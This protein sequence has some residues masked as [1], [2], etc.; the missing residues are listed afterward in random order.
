MVVFALCVPTN[1]ALNWLLI[2]GHLGLPPLG[3]AGSGYASAVN[4]WLMLL[5]LAAVFRLGHGNDPACRC[6][7]RGR[8]SAPISA[9]SWRWGCRLPGCRRWRSASSVFSMVLMGLFGADALAAHQ[10]A[11][12]CASITFMV[13]LGLGQAAT[14][15]V[16]AE[17][18]A[19]KRR[20]RRGGRRWPRYPWRCC[21]WPPRPRCWRHFRE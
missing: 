1:A 10:I 13:P 12:N 15:R 14:V 16:A 2:F 3:L 20:G 21:S 19:G 9:A 11:I 8:R 17:R 18:G 6:A 5:G 7:R 4:Q